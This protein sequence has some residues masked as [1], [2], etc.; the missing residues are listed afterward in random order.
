MVFL[1]AFDDIECSCG[2]CVY[3]EECKYPECLE[4]SREIEEF[5]EVNG[6]RYIK[7]YIDFEYSFFRPRMFFDIGEFEIL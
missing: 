3:R 7:K 4:L 1:M 2:N 5:K 6:V